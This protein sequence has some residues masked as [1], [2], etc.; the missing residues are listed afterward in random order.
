MI[1]LI[2]FDLGNVILPFEHR[3]I[4]TK[5][6]NVSRRKCDFHPEEVF[7]FLFAI[8]D[9]FV[10][11]YEKGCMSSMEFFA[12]IRSRYDL[13]LTYEGFTGIWNEIF[14]EDP[15]MNE[16]VGELKERGYPLFI[17]SNTSELHFTHIIDRYPVIHSF[18]EWI[19]S[20][21]VGAKKPD[22]RIFETVFEKMD[23]APGHVVYIDDI[24]E[25][26]GAARELGMQGIVF[27]GV[28]RLR[29]TLKTYGVL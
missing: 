8:D 7:Q 12:R 27:R 5:L 22:R 6:H 28:D 1:R 14:F 29:E 17:L 20:F 10:N 9:G 25:F 21:E 23:V 2:V 4:A 13:D 3:Q 18:D 16:L 26:V 15:G 24:E 11:G 19:L